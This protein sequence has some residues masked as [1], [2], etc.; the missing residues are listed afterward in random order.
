VASFIIAGVI[1]AA[2]K[3]IGLSTKVNTTRHMRTSIGSSTNSRPKNKNTKRLHG[4]KYRGQ[5]R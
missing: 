4:K 2:R 1:M 5:G 3:S